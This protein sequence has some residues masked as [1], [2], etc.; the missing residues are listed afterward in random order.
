MNIAIR[1]AVENDFFELLNLIKDFADFEN[2]SDKMTNSLEQM[3][4]EKDFFN[5]FVAVNKS[6]AIIGYVVYFFCY[7]TWAG[8]SL[9]MDDLYVK[10]SFRGQGIGTEL[11]KKVIDFGK[12]QNC[13]KLRWQVSSWNKPAVSFYK[14]LGAN[15]DHI[16][17]NCDLL[18]D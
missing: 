3:K 2:C 8:K 18:L 5:C 10:D 15:I 17:K 14:N 16:E 11:I 7:H 13:H 1:P 6:G 4:K 9:Y 12:E